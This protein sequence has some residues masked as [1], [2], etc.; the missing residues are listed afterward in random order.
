M[1]KQK[2]PYRIRRYP[3]QYVDTNGRR[4]WVFQLVD[5]RTDEVQTTMRG[6]GIIAPAYLRKRQAN[7][8]SAYVLDEVLS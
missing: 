3:S 2:L 5:T 8:N 6:N 1:S 4:P 7:L